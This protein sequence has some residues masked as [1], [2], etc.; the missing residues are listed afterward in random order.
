MTEEL[1]ELILA[2][3]ARREAEAKASIPTSGLIDQ[4]DV[5]A[6]VGDKGVPSAKLTVDQRRIAVGLLREGHMSV[7]Y[8]GGVEHYMISKKASTK[9]FA[10]GHRS[11]DFK[12]TK[13]YG[14]DRSLKRDV[15]LGGIWKSEEESGFNF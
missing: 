4:A 5:L 10:E 9:K 14:V 13:P 15:G 12:E 8:R 1:R 3:L 6:Y 7:F 11:P 2:E